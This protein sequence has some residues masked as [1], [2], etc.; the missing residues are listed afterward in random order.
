MPLFGGRGN[1]TSGNGDGGSGDENDWR[2]K[3]YPCFR[4]HI[5]FD[6]ANDRVVHN[7]QQHPE[8][9]ED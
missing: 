7:E 9:N 2:R 6:N 4:C 5:G 1:Q 3:P 8:D